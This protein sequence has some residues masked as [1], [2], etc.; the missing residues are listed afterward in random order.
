MRLDLHTHS[1]F[2]RDGAATIEEI[3]SRCQALG[4]DGCAITDHNSVEGS[5]RAVELAPSFG[6]LVIRG[7][8]VST[9]EG[10]LLAYGVSSVIPRGRSVDETIEK[11]H[12]AG[13]IAVVAHPRRFP[14]G[15]GVRRAS[16]S[17]FDAVEVLNGGSS[18]GSNRTSAALAARLGLPGV[19]GSDAHRIEEI[20]RAVTTVPD[21]DSEDMIIESISQGRSGVDGRS[22]SVKETAVYAKE[23]LT[24]WVRGGFKRM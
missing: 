17:R 18:P 5:L 21:A 24:E 3:L 7:S 8:E 6:L 12:E 4:L 15:M 9:A 11:I 14:S 23:T 13:G 1:R 20:G 19:G 2:S 16:R 22:R 10:H